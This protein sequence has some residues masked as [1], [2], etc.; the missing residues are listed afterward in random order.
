[1]QA[2]SNDNKL[3]NGKAVD[4]DKSKD[5]AIVKETEKDVSKQTTHEQS[6][7]TENTGQRLFFYLYIYIFFF[8]GGNYSG[9]KTETK[10][11][12][13]TTRMRECA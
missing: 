1:M 7:S 8:G 11:V 12:E 6:D 5:Q 13:K 10:C 3:G 9:K 4:K 2:E